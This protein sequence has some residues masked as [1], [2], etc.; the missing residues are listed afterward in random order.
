MSTHETKEHWEQHYGERDRIWSGRVNVQ[1]ADVVADLAPGQALDLGCGEGADAVWL[2]ERGWKVTAVDISDTALGRARKAASARKVDDRI[3]FRQLD[4]SEGFP[5]GTFDLISSQF[6][7]SKLPLDRQKIL[8][9]ATAALRPGGTLVI[10]DHGSAPPWASK[11]D[12]HHE[13]P[14]RKRSSPVWAAAMTNSSGYVSIRSSGTRSART[15][16]SG[17]GWTTSSWCVAGRRRPSVSDSD[18]HAASW[19]TRPRVKRSPDRTTETPCRTGAADHPLVDFTG[20][21]RVVKTKPWRWGS[22]VAVPRD[23]ARGRCSSSRNSPP[24]W[25]TPGSDRLITTCSGN[26]KSPYRSRRVGR[27]NRP[28][29]ASRRIAVDLLWPAARHWSSQSSR[30]SGHGVARPSLAHQ[31]RAIG[32]NRGYSARFELVDRL[33]VGPLEV[34]VLALAEPVSGHVDRGTEPLIIGVQVSKLSRL[35]LGD[36]LG[37][38]RPADIVDLVGHGIP[39][40]RVDALTPCRSHQNSRAARTSA[41]SSRSRRNFLRWSPPA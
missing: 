2:A 38:Q 10:V 23:C 15:D 16:S 5:E 39:V 1:F 21:S 13:F 30:S 19:N 25:S 12:H 7:H 14:A 34:A 27:S 33:R 3:E 26:T 6:L 40:R 28:V 24:V 29:V 37:E 18:C 31:S 41:G 17:R 4:L 32:S 20:R 22:S 35:G 11:L 8:V 9:N 36:Q